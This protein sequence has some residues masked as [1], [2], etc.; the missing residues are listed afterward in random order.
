MTYI[1]C[2]FALKVRPPYVADVNTSGA[3]YLL[4]CR[5]PS[6]NSKWPVFVYLHPGCP[7]SPQADSAGNGRYISN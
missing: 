5:S 6:S 4:D 7:V 2:A 3:V 1:G